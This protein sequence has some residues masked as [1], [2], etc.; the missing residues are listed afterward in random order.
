MMR[1]GSGRAAP[2]VLVR[3]IAVAVG[4]EV[5]ILLAV[6]VDAVVGFVGRARVDGWVAIVAVHFVR[7][8]VTVFIDPVIDGDVT[9]VPVGHGI[10]RTQARPQEQE[11]ESAKT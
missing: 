9:G 7:P 3:D 10:G 1:S 8:C 5:I 4:I 2:L 11:T 6:G